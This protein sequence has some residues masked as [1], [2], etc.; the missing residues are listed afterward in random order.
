MPT[1]RLNNIAA[2]VENAFNSKANNKIPRAGAY[3]NVS[4][5]TPTV[6]GSVT[7][8][9]EDGNNQVAQSIPVNIEQATDE[10]RTN[11]DRIVI[12]E[13][14]GEGEIFVDVAAQ[15]C[16]VQVVWSDQPLGM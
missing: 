5:T 7:V 16:N 1:L 4:A 9:A 13:L 14:V 3:L 12:D 6:G 8:Q 2:G 15:I 11:E 10:I